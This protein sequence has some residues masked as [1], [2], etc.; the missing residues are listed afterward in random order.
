MTVHDR[1]GI[2]LTGATPQSRDR[3]E[4][5]CDLF[6]CYIGDPQAEADAAI[7]GSPGFA[8]AHVLKGWL[9]VLGTEPAGF[10][11]AR[12]SH[13]QA[14]S[15]VT[16]ARERGHLAA[17]GLLLDGQWHG[18]AQALQRV[19]I[20]HPRDLLALQV[21]HL[22]D[23]F[24]GEARLLRDRVARALPDWTEDRPGYHA[25]LSMHS[26]GLEECGDYD[27]AER[28]GKRAIE[29]QPR[30]G[31]AQHAVAH[32]LEMQCRHRD[33][34]AW[35]L[36]DTDRWT[37]DSFSAVH[38]WWHAALFHLDLGEIDEALALFDGPIHG[39][40]STLILNLID[41]SAL[42]WRLDLRGIDVGD[43]WQS[44]AHNWAALGEAG[45]GFYAFSDIHAV[46]ALIR[47]GETD[48][49][50]ATFDAMERAA[51]GPGDNATF[52]RD[53]GLPVSRAF[54]AFADGDFKRTAELLLR[55]L[56]DAYRFGG[57]HAQRDL[58]DLTLIEAAFRAGDASLAR[59]LT[60]E[61]R[62]AKPARPASEALFKRARALPA[63]A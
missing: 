32:V 53:V 18:A 60:A 1:E 29:L 48:R 41:A 61:R 8:M 13:A 3:Y 49:L 6:L 28:Q 37:R 52:T 30:D 4:H 44:V 36:D 58:L 22:L 54:K 45:A 27:R 11:V 42:L 38:S 10:V 57:S 62:L 21:G 63:P 39:D 14:A 35:M 50:A 9:N 7:A 17:L 15:L 20:D 59:A 46:L 24:T 23:F 26:F 51:A 2:V 34:L 25:L 31:W 12:A 43:R 19:S 56:P 5:G 47:G 40:K 33:G 55:V 16:T